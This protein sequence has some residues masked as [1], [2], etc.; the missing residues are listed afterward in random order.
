M[1]N[2][3]GEDVLI[4][5]RYMYC[6]VICINMNNFERGEDRLV[7]CC[8]PVLWAGAPMTYDRS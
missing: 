5:E 6:P 8:I 2:H 4:R 7:T 3:K 1:D